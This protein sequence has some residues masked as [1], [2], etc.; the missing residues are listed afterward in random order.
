MY[1]G[2]VVLRCDDAWRTML[3]LTLYEG[4]VEWM[5]EGLSSLPNSPF[6]GV[7]SVKKGTGNSVAKQWSS[8]KEEE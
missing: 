6:K 3:M 5:A 7:W 8:G 4:D 2:V 1:D